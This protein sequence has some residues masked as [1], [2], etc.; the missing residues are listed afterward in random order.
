[1]FH[2]SFNSSEKNK[3]L[4]SVEKIYSFLSEKYFDRNS[5]IVVIGGGIIGDVAG[6]A[7]SS[8]MRGIKFF[9]VPTTLLSM[10]DSS[11]GGKTGV[12]FYKRKNLVG[13]FYQ[14][15]A[16]FI[17]PDFLSSLPKRELYSG[18]GEVFKY[19]FLANKKNYSLIKQNLIKLFNH[20]VVDYDQI[21]SACLKIKASIVK[22]D[23]K[24]TKGLRKV[25]NLGHTFAHAFEVESNYKIKHGEAVIAGIFCALNLSEKSGYLNKNK[26]ELFIRD[27]SFFKIHNQ[28]KK[29]ATENIFE[30]MSGDK[31]NELGQIKLVLLQDVG[32]VIVDAILDK[33]QIISAIR[34]IKDF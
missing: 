25:L 5:A 6:F 8:Y 12:N 22:Q 18:A 23:E 9:Q 1:V 32:N 19:S 15:E 14:P 16:V 27:F 24:E 26:L 30:K 2:F 17:N 28:I 7:A 34:S 33:K 21:I 20:Q 31:K 29:F 4:K 10:V 3:S 13:T 11:V